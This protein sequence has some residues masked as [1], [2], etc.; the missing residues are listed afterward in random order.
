[1][2]LTQEECIVLEM[3]VSIDNFLLPLLTCNGAL[4]VTEGEPTSVSDNWVCEGTQRPRQSGDLEHPCVRMG[5]SS[6]VAVQA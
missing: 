2:H 1:M 4:Y 3:I 6:H 5:L